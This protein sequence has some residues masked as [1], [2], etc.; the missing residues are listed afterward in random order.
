MGNVCAYIE[1][2][3]DI[4]DLKFVNY[5]TY[6]KKTNFIP[7]P[8]DNFLIIFKCN[9]NCNDNNNNR[10]LKGINKFCI[11]IKKPKKDYILYFPSNDEMLTW[12]YA[13]QSFY[14]F[15]LKQKYYVFNFKEKKMKK[16]NTRYKKIKNKK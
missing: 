9:N 11:L 14:Y 16:I 4:E 12:T 8:D 7:I 10:E 1:K 15:D 13:I 6:D 2:A 3:L 5:D